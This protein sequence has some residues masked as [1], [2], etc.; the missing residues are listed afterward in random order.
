V[1]ALDGLVLTF[2]SLNGL[3]HGFR[4]DVV[5]GYTIDQGGI[6]PSIIPEKASGRLWIKSTDLQNLSEIVKRVEASARGIA[7]SLGAQVNIVHEY[8]PFEESVPNLTLI[9]AFSRNFTRLRIPFKSPEETSRSLVY[10]STDYGNVSHVVP[11][12]SPAI[13]LGSDTLSAHTPEFASATI[14]DVGK[15]ALIGITKAM[16]MTGVDVLGSRDV[17]AAAKAE[18]QRYKGS[19]F[20]EVPLRPVY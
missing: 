5:Y 3:R 13:T 9:E 18:F 7:N 19:G 14:S 12:V 2:A 1:N 4:H 11:S 17:V 8:P 16:A 6:S 20:T 15:E 10:A